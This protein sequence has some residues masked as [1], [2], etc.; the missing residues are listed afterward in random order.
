MMYSLNTHSNLSHTP[1]PPP[2]SP[3]PTPPS[4]TQPDNHFHTLSL[5][6]A[7]AT[8]H[9]HHHHT[10]SG[11]YTLRSLRAFTTS[12]SHPSRPPHTLN[13]LGLPT[14][15]PSLVGSPLLRVPLL[16]VSRA[17]CLLCETLVTKHALHG[18]QAQVDRVHVD[19]QT[20][21]VL[22]AP[23]TLFAVDSGIVASFSHM[24]RF[25]VRL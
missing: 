10:L 24:N 4:H 14:L 11:I 21:L 23:S 12:H 2:P 20:L 3:P 9:L 7:S 22:E 19:L 6:Q 25:Y 13:P 17:V 16:H 1:P 8:S 5:L 15:P 18:E